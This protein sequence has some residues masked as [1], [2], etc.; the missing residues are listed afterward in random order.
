MKITIKDAWRKS[1]KRG[2]RMVN[3]L[4]QSPFFVKLEG[5]AQKYRVYEDWTRLDKRGSPHSKNWAPVPLV[6]IILGVKTDI[7]EDQ[8]IAHNLRSKS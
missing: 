5:S 2:Y 3:G 6:L 8:I 1:P 4:A 7:P